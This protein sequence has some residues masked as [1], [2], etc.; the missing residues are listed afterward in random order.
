MPSIARLAG[1]DSFLFPMSD[2]KM[3]TAGTPKARDRGAGFPLP[4]G[5]GTARAHVEITQS[6]AP[7]ILAG[8][9][10]GFD[11]PGPDGHSL[12]KNTL[13]QRCLPT[14]LRPFSL[15]TADEVRERAHLILDAGFRPPARIFSSRCLHRLG[16]ARRVH[17]S[18]SPAKP[19][20]SL[21]IPF[22]SSWSHFAIDGWDIWTCFRLFGIT[23][24]E[25]SLGRR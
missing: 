15:L 1:L 9:G 11:R 22:H 24:A 10:H 2:M 5:D 6:V 23:V 12:R 18:R 16:K 21:E 3:T 20:R 19:I 8:T 7:G 17:G 14:P 4:D 13:I 25:R